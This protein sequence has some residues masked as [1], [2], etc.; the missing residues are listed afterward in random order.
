ASA[1]SG[2]TYKHKKAACQERAKSMNFG[3]HLIKKNRW[4]KDCIAGKHPA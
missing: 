3:I 1:A 2:D 4:V